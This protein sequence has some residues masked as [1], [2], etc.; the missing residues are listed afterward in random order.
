MAMTRDVVKVSELKNRLSHCLRQVRS[1]RALLVC[2]R[3]RVI[4]R[5]EPAGGSDATVVGDAH[6]LADLERRGTVRRAKHALP[7]GWVAARPKV[8]ADMVGALV[9]EREDGR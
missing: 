8:R 2:D 1:G 5:I 3:D 9:A 7:R 6:W 4:A